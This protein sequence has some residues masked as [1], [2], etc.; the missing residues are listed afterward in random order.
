M[1]GQRDHDLVAGV[2]AL[3]AYFHVLGGAGYACPPPH[4]ATET[5]A[6]SPLSRSFAIS[7]GRP[8]LLRA[9]YGDASVVPVLENFPF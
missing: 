2:D 8:T 5:F 9:L 3:P 6:G 1:A 7:G 4:L